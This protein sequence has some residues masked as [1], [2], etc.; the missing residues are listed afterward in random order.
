MIRWPLRVAPVVVL[1]ITAFLGWLLATASGARVL[2]QELLPAF[3]SGVTI[4]SMDGT[5]WRGL[6]LRGLAYHDA[7]TRVAVDHMR[8][9][10][11]L[12]RLQDRQLDVTGIALGHLAI[13][14]PGSG[15]GSQGG[16]GVVL[17]L[18]LHLPDVRVDSIEILQQG[19]KTLL[20]D[21]RANVDIDRRLQIHTLQLALAE[22]P[23]QLRAAGEVVLDDAAMPLQLRLDWQGELPQIGPAGGSARVEGT[24]AGLKLE[25]H[26]TEPYLLNTSG[27]VSGLDTARPGLQLKGDWRDLHWPL[28]GEPVVRSESGQYRLAGPLDALALDLQGDLSPQAYPKGPLA[29][30]ATLYPDRVQLVEATLHTASGNLRVSGAI[31]YKPALRWQ[32]KLQ[33]EGIDAAL[34]GEP[35]SGRLDLDADTV[36]RMSAEGASGSFKLHGLGGQLRGYPVAAQGEFLFA[37]DKVAVRD[38]R[39]SSGKAR[40]TLDGPVYPR[41]D[42]ALEAAV[43]DLGQLWPGL[44]GKLNGRGRVGGDLSNPQL[45]GNF[46]GEQLVF[47]DLRADQLDMALAW[48]TAGHQQRPSTVKVHGLSIADRHWDTAELSLE[49]ATKEHRL[50]AVLRGGVPDVEL[51]LQGGWDGKTWR[52]EMRQV[53]LQ[54][55]GKGVWTNQAPA[56]LM[57][58]AD[59][60]RVAPLCLVDGEQSVCLQGERKAAKALNASLHIRSFD[61]TNLAELVPPEYV[62][63]GRVD[64]EATLG[65]TLDRPLVKASLVPRDGSI[66]LRGLDE[67]APL[68][69]RYSNAH[70]GLDY[71][72][73]KLA[74]E[75]ELM[76]Q[77]QAQATLRLVTLPGKGQAPDRLQGRIQVDLPD[78]QVLAPLVP[79]ARIHGGSAHLQAT[80]AGTL[81]QPRVSGDMTLTDAELEYPDLGLDLK[82]VE[83]R[84]H[85]EGDTRIQIAGSAT[86]GEGKL[87]LDG[88]VEMAP[89]ADWPIDLHVRGDRVLAVRLPD[90]RVIVS[91]DLR[92]KG[93]SRELNVEGR[94]AIPEA[95]IVV[96]ELPQGTVRPS[97]DEVVVGARQPEAP[98]SGTRVHGK[99]ELELGDKVAFSGFGLKTRLEGL[100][101]LRFQPGQNLANG[102]I[103][104]REGRYR[105]WGQDLSIEQGRLLFAGPVDNPGVDLRAVR[106]SRDGEVK[107]YLE[108]GGTLRKPVSKVR[109]EPPTSSSDALSYLLNGTALGES[110]DGLGQAQLLQAAGALGLEKT[111][112]ALQAIKQE[113]GLD[114]LG[115]DSEGGLE[116][117]A[118][119]AGKYLSPDLYARYIQGLFDSSAVLSLRYKLSRHLSVETR[120]GST[121]SLE[122]TY[123]KEHD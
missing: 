63:H 97:E 56:S 60:A 32:L 82:A 86:S 107:A 101:G 45:N 118:L 73:R 37:P 58:A 43:P 36:G 72:D 70:L 100:L 71:R 98:V 20:S 27:E 24:T 8:W 67:E 66:Q 53:R 5:L 46:K 114:E 52:G 90:T 78:L 7:N 96:R 103:E 59:G 35:W 84:L 69:V 99:V 94:V 68:E 14:L 2:L 38:T 102:N 16:G 54:R 34:L 41:F 1:A 49:G 65:G 40:I 87:Q 30:K 83:L 44:A 120:S 26:L 123:S 11:D 12:S 25:H 19:K 92:I 81:E 95:A 57:L 117:S 39:L 116:G 10:W 50:H 75:A 104:L 6:S 110:G 111:L 76:L 79:Q 112:P 61:L 3:V 15:A 22:P 122:F 9:T 64:G 47:A 108:V 115:V 31:D 23:L 109:T 93:N 51:A 48:P 89:Q 88:Q 85:S 29:L 13:E 121:Q 33:G 18:S 77:D 4:E 80:L 17:P 105:A 113:S 119:V 106:V 62:L 42:F 55:L 74:A 91:P 21:I 28:Q